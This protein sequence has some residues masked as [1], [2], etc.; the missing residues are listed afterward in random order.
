[1]KQITLLIVNTASL[2][3]A[4]FMNG[5]SNTGAFNGKTVGEVSAENETLF[6]PAGYAFSIW[7]LIYILLI[8]FV[9]WQWVAWFKHNDDRDLKQ[10][11]IW[12]ALSSFA[13]G[14]WIVA[15]LYG[16]VGISVVLMLVLLVSL[17]VLT[18][19]LRLEIWDAPKRTI[20][21]VWWPIC[22]YLGW[23]IV[24]SVANIAA[25]LVSINWQGAYM[26]AEAWTVTMIIAAA[27]IYLLLIYFR[28]LREAA[29]VGIWALVAIAVKQ[30]QMQPAIVAAA[31]AAAVVLFVAIAY[32]A[33][34]NRAPSQFL[35]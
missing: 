13:N 27:I 28:N 10:T 11:G 23:I 14:T 18:V 12:F 30:W 25:F 9:V 5:L 24:A 32:N 8:M 16:N 2:L 29:L 22:V 4:L 21:F 17:I 34:K 1:M 7:G 33:Y 19:R 26:G 20:F 3:F 35:R 6:A 15:W 31:I